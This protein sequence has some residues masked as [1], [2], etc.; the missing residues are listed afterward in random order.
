VLTSGR[1]KERVGTAAALLLAVAA[2][3]MSAAP[4]SAAGV[5]AR[6]ADPATSFTA[7][8]VLTGVAATSASNAWAVGT[9]G[10][11]H[12]LIARWNGTTWTQVS[13]PN[14]GDVNGLAAVAATSASNAWAVGDDVTSS[15]P[16]GV[17]LIVHWNGT[18][19]TQV[20]SPNPNPKNG[21]T[22]TGVAA[23]SATNAW[24]VG[25]SDRITGAPQPLILHWNGTAWTQV[26]SPNPD[27]T[28]GATLAGVVSTSTSS[29]WAVGSYGTTTSPEGQPLTVQ[30]NGTV[31][32]QVP[33][34]NPSPKNG[35]TL[36]G[37]AAASATS[38]WAVGSLG[39][40]RTLIMHGNGTNWKRAPSPNPVSVAGDLL[41]GVAAVSV[42]DAWAVGNINVKSSAGPIIPNTLI[43]RWNGTAWKLVP[44]PN[45]DAKDGDTLNA[46][47][48]TSATNAWAVGGTDIPQ[49]GNPRTVIL[50]WNGAAW[51]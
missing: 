13:S 17:P 34:P 16:Q 27:P 51:G 1:A 31:W 46:V 40:G 21:T 37:V 41:H 19:W 6:S 12:T 28:R 3:G 39:N 35:D 47:S 8:G 43:A 23:T 50:H 2:A 49:G 26:P 25:E 24:A 7:P 15:N 45:P 33:S 10:N 42:G 18:A 14:P 4:A 20:P 22:L 44:S 36:T 11:G 38:A 5:R 9:D 32:K 29:A 48:A 30:W